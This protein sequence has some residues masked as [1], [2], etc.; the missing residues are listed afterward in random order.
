MNIILNYCKIY[1]I[2]FG[3]TVLRFLYVAEMPLQVTYSICANE[4]WEGN[5]RKTV[6]TTP[7]YHFC[8][9][10]Y[11]IFDCQEKL[12]LKVQDVMRKNNQ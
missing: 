3:R 6:T 4:N 11:K 5:H 2:T 8:C 1:Y 10:E 9:V 12:S 7:C